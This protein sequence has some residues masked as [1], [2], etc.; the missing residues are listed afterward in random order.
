MAMRKAKE[1]DKNHE[2]H[3]TLRLKGY[4]KDNLQSE[5]QKC[6]FLCLCS[7]VCVSS[8][9]HFTSFLS[10]TFGIWLQI[11]TNRFSLS[12]FI[13]LLRFHI[14]FELIE[15]EFLRIIYVHHYYTPRLLYDCFLISFSIIPFIFCYLLQ[16]FCIFFLLF[17]A[18]FR[19]CCFGWSCFFIA[20]DCLFC[21]HIVL[22]WICVRSW[23][24]V[25]RFLYMFAYVQVIIRWMFDSF[26][27][28]FHFCFEGRTTIIILHAY[29]YIHVNDRL[30]T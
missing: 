1:V 29:M 5:E 16:Q 26:F 13:C 30:R 15:M 14:N 11:H 25:S 7:R 18:Y 6:S 9:L 8:S 28:P 24:S 19:C 22:Y 10:F 4:H 3:K 23:M 20:V 17:C 2:M 12:L 21:I 27:R